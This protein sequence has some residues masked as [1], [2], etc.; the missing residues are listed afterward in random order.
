MVTK[1]TTPPGTV[2]ITGTVTAAQQIGVWD[3][4]KNYFSA[5]TGGTYTIYSANY[6]NWLFDSTQR[7]TRSKM[8]V[9]RT[10]ATSL[11]N[12]LNGVNVGLMRYNWRGSGGMVMYPVSDVAA[13]RTNL[14]NMVQSWA[15]T[16]ITPLSET[17][18]EAY[19][20]F[21]GGAVD[22][23][24]ASWS[25]TCTSWTTPK[26]QCSTAIA[27][28]QPSVAASRSTG[29]LAGANYDSPADQSCRKNFIVYL[30]DGLP[31]END[32]ADN[33]IKALPNFAS[34]GGSCDATQFPGANGGL[35][36]AALAQYMYNADLRPD[37]AKVQNVTSYFIGFG[38]DFTSGGAPTAAY[39]YLN[40]AATRGGGKAY[41]ADTLTGLTGAFNDILAEVIKTNT[42]F[43]APAVAVNA[44]N[45][46]QTLNDLYFSVFSPRAT[47]HWPGNVKKYKVIGGAVVDCQ[48]RGRDR[49]EYRLLPRQRQELLEFG[50]RWRG[51]HQG[52]RCQRS[53]RLLDAH[54][55][56]LHRQHQRDAGQCDP[57]AVVGAGHRHVGDRRL[58][59]HRQSW[60]PGSRRT[61]CLG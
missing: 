42:T 31:N 1:T 59:E 43:S 49:F 45:R 4:S 54:H 6:M 11:L 47:Y 48:R 32:L 7:S 20:Y 39:T 10:A 8:S 57:D 61:R 52:R 44:F 14:V 30:T 21:A 36:T 56:Y 15:P 37:V 35:C 51:C 3:V 26:Q 5:S 17:Y 38:S 18:F 25:T 34:L 13:N 16:G 53:A 22:F 29:T 60:R 2:T 46:T 27:F 55:L 23:G 33:D 50:H 58:P 41:T 19:R 12:S 40:N 28:A 9:M 24:N